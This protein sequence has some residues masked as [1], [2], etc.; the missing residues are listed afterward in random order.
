MIENDFVIDEDG[1]ITKYTGVKT[2][3]E[4]PQTIRGVAVRA[5]GKDAFIKKR[6]T[7]I[8]I[9]NGV[10][11]IGELAFFRNQ[12]IEIIIPE[13]VME[14]GVWAF[15]SNQLTKIVIPNIVTRIG[16]CAFLSNRLVEIIIPKSVTEIEKR[17][18]ADNQLNSITI[19][20]RVS[21]PRK[22]KY[23]EPAFDNGFDDFYKS[24]KKK[25]GTYLFDGTDWSIK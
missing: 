5:I 6:L 17:A 25:S 11:E 12:L 20:G 19:Y 15:A 22:S 8:V 3:I 2:E 13:S 16:R 21:L 10:T 23:S 18:F 4:I 7:S 24:N 14:I 9:P 1:V